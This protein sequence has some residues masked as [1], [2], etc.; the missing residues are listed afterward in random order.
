[1]GAGR[2]AEGS[3]GRHHHRRPAA[4]IE[5]VS[6]DSQSNP[7]RA[8]EV[9]SQLINNDNVD[10]MV[11][12]STADTLDP[13]SDQCELA[14]CPAS[15]PTIRGRTV[16][17]RKG[18]PAKGFDW[19]YHFFW[20]FG[21]VSDLFTDMWQALPTNKTLGLMFTNDPDGIAANDPQHGLPPVITKGGVRRCTI[22]ASIRRSPE[23]FTA[24]ITQ[25]KKSDCRD[26]LRH[27]QPAAIRHLLDPVRP[28]G[29]P[30]R[31]S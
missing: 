11:A 25:L 10:I 28:A 16:F 2:G 1:M 6:R 19:T 5:I 18:D 29:L 4:P 7:N 8:S 26:E 17:G 12:S 9:A 14:A 13:V 3:R 27:L 22:S 23:D 20:G 15:P 31:R 24:Q 21:M 30:P